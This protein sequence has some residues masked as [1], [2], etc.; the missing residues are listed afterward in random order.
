MF[1][2]DLQLLRLRVQSV[3]AHCASFIPPRL[4]LAKGHSV[5][6]A[7]QHLAAILADGRD[8]KPILKKIPGVL[9]TYVYNEIRQSP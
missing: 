5:Q 8:K 3:S 2:G 6:I 7:D 4:N 9:R 1:S